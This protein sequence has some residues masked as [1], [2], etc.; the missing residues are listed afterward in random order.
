MVPGTFGLLHIDVVL[1]IIENTVNP[2]LSNS[3]KVREILEVFNV[4]FTRCRGWDSA[5]SFS[6]RAKYCRTRVFKGIRRMV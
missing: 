3:K 1:C 5:L 2:D 6:P 4:F